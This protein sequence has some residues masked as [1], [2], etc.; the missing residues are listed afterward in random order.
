MQSLV[1]HTLINKSRDSEWCDV[2]RH[3]YSNIKY[4]PGGLIEFYITFYVI[5]RTWNARAPFLCRSLHLPDLTY[6]RTVTYIKYLGSLV[7][8]CK[9]VTYLSV[10][11]PTQIT[12]LIAVIARTVGDDAPPPTKCPLWGTPSV[13]LQS[14]SRTY[15]V[16]SIHCAYIL[17]S[18]PSFTGNHWL[19]HNDKQSNPNQRTRKRKKRKK[20]HQM[21]FLHYSPSTTFVYT[22]R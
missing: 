7:G 5:D 18:L 11:Q 2:T 1:V 16:T 17:F 3:T 6:I 4:P 12:K 15:N 21:N 8:I 10:S 14:T 22:K 13:A 20:K 9:I 19:D